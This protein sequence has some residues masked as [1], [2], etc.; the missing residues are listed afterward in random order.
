MIIYFLQNR[1]PPILPSLHQR[2]HNKLT[3]PDG[4]QSAFADDLDALVGFGEKNQ[5]SLGA[6]LFQFFR[7]YGYE[8]DYENAV[9]S[10]REGRQVSKVDKGW[11]RSINNRLCVEEP[12]NTGRNLGNTA[13]D[14]SFRG[15]HLEL[16]RAFDLISQGK[17]AECCEK[18]VFPKVE[19]RLFVR[20]PAKKSAVIMR[21]TSTSSNRGG[22]GSR[23]GS[24]SRGNRHNNHPSRNGNSNRR[25][26]AGAFDQ[27][28]N[29]AYFPAMS[30]NLVSQDA[31]IQRQAQA[32]AQLHNDLYATYSVLQAQENNLRLQLYAQGLQNQAYAQSQAHGQG[33]GSANPP[34]ATDRNRTSSFDQPPLTVPLRSEMYF[35]PM[36]YPP[37]QMYYQSPA[38][39]PP[40]PSLSAA[41]PDL[42]RSMHRTTVTTGSGHGPSS[43]ALRS[44]S[45]PATRSGPPPLAQPG[46]G[47]GPS[48]L[49]IYNSA[50]PVNGSAIPSFIPDEASEPAMDPS[51]G[52]LPSPHD[53]GTPKEYVGY[54]F[55]DPTPY[56]RRQQTMSHPVPTF[57]DLDP[58]RAGPR[59]LSTEQLPQSILDRMKRPSRSQSPL[60]HDRSFSTGGPLNPGHLP[61]G[62]SNN[63]LKALH[64]QS[65]GVVNGSNPVPLS[66]PKWRASISDGFVPEERG[67]DHLAGS[68]DSLSQ[69]SRTG[70]EA[71]VEQY[72]SPRDTRQ[73]GPAEPPLVVNGSVP[74][75]KDAGV[76]PST[77]SLSNGHVPQPIHVSNGFLPVDLSGNIRLSPNS[78]NRPSRH[79]GGISPLDIG[80]SHDFPRDD[81]VHLSPVYENR[82]PSPTT[83]RKV[84]PVEKRLTKTTPKGVDSHTKS[85]KTDS[86]TIASS[87]QVQHGLQPP[88]AALPKVNG[89]TR[90]SK[91]EG[92]PGNWQKITK[93]KKKVATPEVKSIEKFPAHVN[94]RKGG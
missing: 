11:H 30:P 61:N 14:N 2:P 78:R 35:Y 29:P 73:D 62:I 52:P 82:A 90:A 6:L 17:L 15:L 91:S 54:Y 51:Y 63:N 43:S 68:L 69:V 16:R 79:N 86:S 56:W 48:G 7:F 76:I 26:S 89:H 10:V 55:N 33:N 72:V 25:S 28:Y 31:W 84:E 92:A 74:S 67:G 27:N 77:P 46:G 3:H 41:T 50:R 47:L 37:N 81:L 83:T 1:N 75:K 8:H 66:I 53:E 39:N 93:S 5:D 9:I 87:G 85:S 23:S 58:A 32:Q 38:T 64:C 70:S 94:E 4:S 24:G 19:E 44:Q 80:L 45:Q 57:G 49:G 20:A 60:G 22:G 71:S 88:P 65:P 12:F 21:S 36:Q 34:P 59:R 13:D 42:R 18:Y 40:S